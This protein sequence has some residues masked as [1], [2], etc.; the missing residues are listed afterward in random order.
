MVGTFIT[1]EGI[2]GCGKT[3][4]IR[5]LA[6][7]LRATGLSLLELRE[8]GGTTISERIR[9]L[10]LDVRH[11]DMRDECELLLY[12][13]SRAQLTQQVILPALQNGSIVLCDRFFDSTTAYQAGGRGLDEQMVSRANALG[14]CGVIPTRTLVF[15]L[16]PEEAY[17]RATQ[18]TPDRLEAEGL[19]FQKRVQQGYMRI[20]QQEPDRVKLIDAS[21]TIE[22]V[23]VRVKR[24]LADIFVEL[25][26]E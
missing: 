15:D 2:D 12:E 16:D 1:L 6:Q 11:H 25:T 23:E 18:T 21:G 3:T 24:A 4:Q 13:A 19:A 22:Q 20:A 5:R 14:C 26:D 17:A 8:P 7:T 9:D 10:L